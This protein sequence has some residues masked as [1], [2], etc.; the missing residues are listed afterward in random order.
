MDIFMMYL[1]IIIYTSN[2]MA[3]IRVRISATHFEAVFYLFL[4]AAL[5]N[6]TAKIAH[7]EQ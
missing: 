6:E 5:A 2:Y 4:S 1:A 3:I 7:Q